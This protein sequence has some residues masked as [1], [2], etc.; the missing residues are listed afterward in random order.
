VLF[1]DSQWGNGG[2]RK[3]NPIGNM[4][5][6]SIIF[7]GVITERMSF[8]GFVEHGTVAVTCNCISLIN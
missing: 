4:N 8:V 6:A 3:A 1:L 7:H 5:D 2:I